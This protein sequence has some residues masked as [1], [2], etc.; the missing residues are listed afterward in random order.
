MS[1]VPSNLRAPNVYTTGH[2]ENG[3]SVILPSKPLT[4]ENKDEG[5]TAGADIYVTNEAPVDFQDRKGMQ[6][7][8]TSI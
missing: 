3:D 8:S 1:H 2:A 7:S 5:K 4:W 6:T